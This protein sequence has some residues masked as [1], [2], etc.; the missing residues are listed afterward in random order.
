[1][2]GTVRGKVDCYL[3]ET[4]NTSAAQC[5]YK[6]TYDFLMRLV[7]E[8]VCERVARHTGRTSGTTI[9]QVTATDFYDGPNP[10]LPNCW[11]VFRFPANAN[12]PYDWYLQMQTNGTTTFGQAPGNP[13]FAGVSSSRLQAFQAA[14]GVGGSPWAG[15]MNFAAGDPPSANDSRASTVWTDPG[16]GLYVFPRSNATGGVRA[17]PKDGFVSRATSQSVMRVHLFAD[18]DSF[19]QLVSDGDTGAYQWTYMG[20]YE[21][22]EGLPTQYNFVQMS[23]HATGAIANLQSIGPTSGGTY[24]GGIIEASGGQV[25]TFRLDR[26]DGIN[27]WRRIPNGFTGQYDVFP[28]TMFL[29]E[30]PVVGYMGQIT[31]IQETAGLVSHDA[32]LDPL[33]N[34]TVLSDNAV[35]TTKMVTPWN[36]SVGAAPRNNWTRFGVDF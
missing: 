2:A 22:R 5:V 34:R 8:G 32:S 12:R 17:T 31:F 33:L 21:P 13:G 19:L 11:S 3:N 4:D 35:A 7:A 15:T 1:M 18:D 25:R 14:I 36:P 28:Y 30:P 10:F 24:D 6:L 26:L 27:S 29:I 23:N 9:Q 16:D 20:L